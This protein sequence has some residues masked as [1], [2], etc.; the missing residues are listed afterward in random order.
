MGTAP[1]PAEGLAVL[2]VGAGIQS[3]RCQG[4]SSQYE[5]AQ[6]SGGWGSISGPSIQGS[7]LDLLLSMC[8]GG[9]TNLSA[10]NSLSVLI[11]VK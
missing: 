4:E 1:P 11:R 3:S 10:A 7:E 5:E 8:L 9:M 2:Q 6:C